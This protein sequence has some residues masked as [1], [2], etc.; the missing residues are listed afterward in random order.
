MHN[1][2]YY[3]DYLIVDFTNGEYPNYP[4]VPENKIYKDIKKII[5]GIPDMKTISDFLHIFN[6]TGLIIEVEKW[7][8]YYNKSDER[9]EFGVI[10]SMFGT[11]LSGVN[12]EDAPY[13][14]AESGI[15]IKGRASSWEEEYHLH[16]LKNIWIITRISVLFMILDLSI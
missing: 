10:Y 12:T 9:V 13:D 8:T 11:R 2:I 14:T 1:R 15:F 7:Y 16:A 4:V 5:K 3:N 6:T